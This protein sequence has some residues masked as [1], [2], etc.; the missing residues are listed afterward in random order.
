MNASFG[1]DSHVFDPMWGKSRRRWL[2][3]SWG[4]G[5]ADDGWA[6]S[7]PLCNNRTWIDIDEVED[8]ERMHLITMHQRL[9]YNHVW[10]G[11]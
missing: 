3:K 5:E 1:K 8:P 10:S 6:S 9:S 2:H 4:A 7:L 11:P